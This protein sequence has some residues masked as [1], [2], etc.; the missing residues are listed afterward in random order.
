MGK[1]TKLYQAFGIIKR[2]SGTVYGENSNA[3]IYKK[4]ESLGYRWNVAA[5]TWESTQTPDI[6]RCPF[7]G[8][9]GRIH[10]LS[11]YF[12][13]CNQCDAAGPGSQSEMQAI[14]LWNRRIE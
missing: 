14:E 4:V 1:T 8:G 7:C 13:A 5:R 6:S 11:Q 10:Q 12:V 2:H 3:D 9:A